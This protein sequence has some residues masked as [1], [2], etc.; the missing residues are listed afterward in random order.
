MARPK[1]TRTKIEMIN[2]WGKEHLK[3]F[4]FRFNVDT[5]SDIIKQ[6]EEQPNKAKYIADLIR[7]DIEAQGKEIRI[8]TALSQFAR[9][10]EKNDV[11]ILVFNDNSKLTT[12]AQYLE[13]DNRL[14]KSVEVQEHIDHKTYIVKVRNS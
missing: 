9:T 10:I 5:Q 12:N 11:V 13:N 2:D 7:Q 14:I 4:T 1:G 6:L 3:A 8:T